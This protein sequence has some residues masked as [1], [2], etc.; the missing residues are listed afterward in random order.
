MS[1]IAE[2]SETHWP[3]VT[4]KLK[5]EL[6][7]IAP[8]LHA[9]EQPW[10]H[11]ERYVIIVD[12]RE[13]RLSPRTQLLRYVVHLKQSTPM[14]Q[15]YNAAMVCVLGDNKTARN[16]LNAIN[17]LTPWATTTRYVATMQDAFDMAELILR[18][19]KRHDESSIA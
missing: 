10:R 14:Y 1:K 9:V 18:E 11:K 6:A 12:M 19:D 2:Y 13:V 16:I 7:N 17:C 5:G 3:V 4:L 8:L 15:R